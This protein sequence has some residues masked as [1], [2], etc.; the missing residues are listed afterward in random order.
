[1]ATNTLRDPTDWPVLVIARR[2][3]LHGKPVNQYL[4]IS[5]GE[6]KRFKIYTAEDDSLGESASEVAPVEFDS[7]TDLFLNMFLVESFW[8]MH[9]DTHFIGR[10][11]QKD[12]V[13]DP[14]SFA[15][16]GVAS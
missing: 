4:C 10:W 2:H 9:V 11:L 16:A 14:P 7:S 8:R 6:L 12:F 1:M 15:Y 3:R 5:R 13:V